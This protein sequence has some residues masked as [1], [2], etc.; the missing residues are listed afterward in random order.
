MSAIMTHVTRQWVQLGLW[1]FTIRGRTIRVPFARH[2]NLDSLSLMAK[3]GR[4]DLP[5][6]GLV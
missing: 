4:L 2:T 6:M 5:G 1:G 3:I